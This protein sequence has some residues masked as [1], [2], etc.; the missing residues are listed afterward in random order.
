M[1]VYTDLLNFLKKRANC[2]LQTTERT[3]SSRTNN[4]AK[5]QVF[6]TS[7]KYLI[8]K[9]NHEVRRCQQFRSQPI[10]ERIKSVKRSALCTN[11][12]QTGHA[13]Q[14]CNSGTCRICNER[15]N[16]PLHQPPGGGEKRRHSMCHMRSKRS[17]RDKNS[18]YVHH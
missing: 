17:D 15:H 12:L 4:T 16:T 9:A 6:L 8:C 2:A 14:D 5:R 18:R 13:L 3:T 7:S 11:C 10:H 1:P